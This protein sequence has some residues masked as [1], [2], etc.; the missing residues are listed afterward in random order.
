MKS[1]VSIS[2]SV[3]PSAYCLVTFYFLSSTGQARRQKPKSLQVIDP[4]RTMSLVIHFLILK[5]FQHE[6][7]ELW[8][9]FSIRIL[10]QQDWNKVN[11]HFTIPKFLKVID[12]WQAMSPVI[13]FFI[14]NFFNMS[15]R[16]CNP[17]FPYVNFINET[18]KRCDPF[19]PCLN[20]IKENEKE[21]R[22]ILIYLNF[23][24]SLIPSKFCLW[25]FKV[26]QRFVFLYLNFINESG[27]RCDLFFPY[28]NFVNYMCTV[29]QS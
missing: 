27:K 3:L 15:Y 20:F 4:W 14:L 24:K 19:N 26:N 2:Y 11:I 21:S 25:F 8:S 18:E 1:L 7:K 16:R 5:P 6:W 12:L 28:L 13:R 10:Y 17:F 29:E 22:F 9:I 23:Y